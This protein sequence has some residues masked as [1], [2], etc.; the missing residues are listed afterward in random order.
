MQW[1]CVWW[2]G[3]GVCVFVY[4]HGGVTLCCVCLSV[5]GL[6]RR[7]EIS[8]GP[9]CQ[10]KAC[11]R[12][13][14]FQSFSRCVWWN[15]HF[16]WDLIIVFLRAFAADTTKKCEGPFAQKRNPRRKTCSCGPDVGPCSGPSILRHNK[17]RYHNIMEHLKNLKK[18]FRWSSKLDVQQSVTE[19]W[20]GLWILCTESTR[21]LAASLK[22]AAT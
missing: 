13:S 11:M 6:R 19:P 1:L 18:E 21:G 2:V 8:C 16:T 4:C 7:T 10:K 14:E 12:Q 17:K 5:W 22:F 15:A 9:I 3:C 20:V